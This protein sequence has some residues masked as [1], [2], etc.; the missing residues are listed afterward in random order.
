MCKK[1]VGLLV[2]KEK[3]QTN[4]KLT[5]IN[6]NFDMDKK[7]NI[8]SIVERIDTMMHWLIESL[9]FDAHINRTCTIL[10]KHV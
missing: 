7:T 2:F 6:W 3:K 8:Y 10:G 4:N 9:K 5:N 1:H